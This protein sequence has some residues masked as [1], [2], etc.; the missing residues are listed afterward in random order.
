MN[1]ELSTT[2]EKGICPIDPPMSGIELLIQ[3]AIQTPQ[4]DPKAFQML[5]EQK[6][7]EEDRAAERAF[8]K[9]KALFQRDCPEV[10]HDKKGK[11]PSGI[12][13]TYSSL[14]FIEM[15]VK[16]HCAKHGLSYHW[17]ERDGR[18][19]CILAH[20]DGHR[21]ESSFTLSTEGQQG[22]LT[23]MTRQQQEGA[24]DT[25]ARGRSLT[26]VL[27]IG[28]AQQ[29]LGGAEPE[30][31]E[32]EAAKQTEARQSHIETCKKI[33]EDWLAPRHELEDATD[34]EK[35]RRFGAWFISCTDAKAF[36]P[37]VNRWTPEQLVQCR[38][39]LDKEAATRRTINR[40]RDA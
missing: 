6:R 12:K 14:G 38:T 9:A 23:K 33:R 24:T 39:Q 13:W 25:Y 36:S 21:E 5:L 34:T 37:A 4:F 31:P 29:D 17:T 35:H 26:A 20:R 11:T 16:P 19:V 28:T 10:K 40:R 15:I 27:G 22:G 2:D 32:D 1:K 7:I 30:E 3:T 18:N 8:L